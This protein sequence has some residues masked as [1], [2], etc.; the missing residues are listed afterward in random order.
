MKY[1]K[2]IML[3]STLLTLFLSKASAQTNPVN[4]ITVTN[5][6]TVV[7]TNYVTFTNPLAT[8]IAHIKG[9]STNS[10][11]ST[12]AVA[13][14]T[15]AAATPKFPWNSA[16]TAG[17]TLTRGNSD[18]LLATTKFITD[19]KTP[20]NEF[21]LGGDAAYGSASGVEN[22]ET[23]HGFGQWN[24]LFS[25]RWYGYLR[26]EGLHDGIAEVKYRD[27]TTSGLGYYFV[28]NTNTTFSVEGGPGYIAQRVGTQDDNYATLRVAEKFERKFNKNSARVWENVEYLPRVDKLSDYLINGEV[29]VESAL[30]KT[31][32]LQVF[33]DDNF[34]SVP[35]SGLRRND[36]KLVS[37][38]TY[39]F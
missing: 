14:G 35:A 24:H 31:L 20:I 2:S 19:K 34:N 38:L 7:V 23:F 32:S 5:Y 37:G 12:N 10:V 17:L 11:S 8:L 26:T 27:T 28:K 29:G 3:L 15:K 25:E 13:V 22:V 9:G 30:Y 36:V 16:L 18:T 39:K 21:N 4:Y 33:L 1:C 6:V